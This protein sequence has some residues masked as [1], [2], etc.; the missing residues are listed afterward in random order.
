MQ[1][2]VRENRFQV[3]LFKFV[4]QSAEMLPPTL[5]VPYMKML[6]SLMSCPTTAR[7][8]FNLLKHN[9]QTNISWDHFFNSLNKWVVSNLQIGFLIKNKV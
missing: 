2:K 9:N 5:F 1:D 4:R 8:G 6:A 3:S 7:Q